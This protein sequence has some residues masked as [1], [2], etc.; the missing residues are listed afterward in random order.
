MKPFLTG[1]FVLLLWSLSAC[2]KTSRVATEKAHK[3]PKYKLDSQNGC[4][5]PSIVGGVKVT[6]ENPLIN[7]LVLLMTASKEDSHKTTICSGTLIDKNTVLTAAHC[8]NNAS[9][10]YASSVLATADLYCSSGFNKNLMYEIS[11]VYIHPQYKMENEP[12]KNSPDYD[13]AVVKFSGMLPDHYQPLK[14]SEKNILDET[15]LQ[16]NLQIILSGYG[17]TSTQSDEPPELRF[18][19]KPF[20]F[21]FFNKSDPLT[22]KKIDL[23]RDMSL[24]GVKQTDSRGACNGDSGGPLLLETPNGY[25]IIGVASYLEGYN[26]NTI[27]ENGN[28]YYTYIA[29]YADWIMSFVK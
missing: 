4:F 18:L 20:Q 23:I 10:P 7:H 12:S 9:T 13:L 26:N 27:C 15:L 8:F 14:L 1:I 5:V 22:G 25:E 11:S 3:T 2:Q 16:S 28:I 19:K 21:L 17:R 24:I 29:N 6:N